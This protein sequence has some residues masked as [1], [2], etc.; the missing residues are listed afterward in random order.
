L[1]HGTLLYD[2]DLEKLFGALNPE[3]QD[4]IRKATSSVP[5]PVMNIR[6]F[7]EEKAGIEY[8]AAGFFEDFIQL[9]INYFCTDSLRTFSEEQ[10]KE[11]SV[12]EKKYLSKEWI[13]KL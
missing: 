6:A 12:L 8:G 1:H 11:I 9:L 4:L 2:A 10:V 5:S 7:V 13:Y 3:K